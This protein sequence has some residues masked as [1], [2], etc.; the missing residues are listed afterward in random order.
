MILGFVE[1]GQD[2]D[3]KLPQI[4][5]ARRLLPLLL[6]AAQGGQEQRRENRNDGDDHQ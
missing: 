3:A 2:S 6:R 4:G 1:I 5:F